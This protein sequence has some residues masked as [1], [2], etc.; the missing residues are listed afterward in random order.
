M[1]AKLVHPIF[2][3]FGDGSLPVV[4]HQCRLEHVVIRLPPHEVTSAIVPNEAVRMFCIN[5]QETVLSGQWS[6]AGEFPGLARQTRVGRTSL[7]RPHS[8]RCRSETDLE[9]LA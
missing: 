6:D 3:R 8:F 9:R 5:P 2:K 1:H 7:I 4:I